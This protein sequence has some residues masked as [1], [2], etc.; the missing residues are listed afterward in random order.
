MNSLASKISV[1]IK[2]PIIINVG[3]P[4]HILTSNSRVQVSNISKKKAKNNQ[5]WRYH[6]TQKIKKEAS[7][8]PTVSVVPSANGIPIENNKSSNSK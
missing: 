5:Y 8:P 2:A 1:S 3:S 7:I 4:N 6:S